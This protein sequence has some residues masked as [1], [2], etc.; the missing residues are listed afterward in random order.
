MGTL[1]AYSLYGSIFLAFSF[2]AYRWLLAQRKYGVMNRICLLGIYA[3]ALLAMPLIA[4]ITHLLADAGTATGVITADAPAADGFE[5]ADGRQ[6]IISWGLW[7]YTTGCIAVGLHLLWNISRL[8]RIISSAEKEVC[9]GGYTLIRVAGCRSPYSFGRYIIVGT[10]EPA[11]SLIIAH[12]SAHIT[13]LHR[14]DLWIA[15][16][17]CTLMWYNPVAWL[18]REQLREIHEYLADADVINRGYDILQYQELLIKKAIGTKLQPLTNSL[19]Q[20]NIYKRITMMYKKT[21]SGASRLRVLGLMPALI[22]ATAVCMASPVATATRAVAAT[23]MASASGTTSKVTQ[24]SESVQSPA[25]IA[26]DA[27]YKKA[28][29]P[30]GEN[31][32]LIYLMKNV[33]YPKEAASAGEQGKVVVQFVVDTDGSVNDIEVTQ[34]VTPALDKEAVRVVKSMPRWTPAKD[35][36]GLPV[37]CFFRLP[38]WFKLPDSDATAN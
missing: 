12:E 5:A 14:A 35:K 16:A 21:P 13:Q 19:N 28:E 20:S 4:L 25:G 29:F 37:K 9:P 23:S 27:P 3:M 22:M 26:T 1:F 2:V 18:M 33:V 11:I 24:I 7:I 36:E 8:W 38:V 32:L 34:S 15:Q 17:V 30:G 10:H 6:S 31:D